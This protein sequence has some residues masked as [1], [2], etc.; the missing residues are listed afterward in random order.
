VS[1]IHSTAVIS[2]TVELSDNVEIGPYAVIEG[3]TV[4]GPGVRVGPHAVVHGHVLLAAGV[5]VGAHAMLGGE[6]QDLS[7]R[8]GPTDLAVGRDTV[9]REA[10]I[11]HRSTNPERPTRVGARCLLMGQSHVAHDCQ[12]D[13]Q[14]ILSHGASLAGHVTVGFGAVVGGKAGVHQH[15]RIGQLSMVGGM[16]AV[17]RDVLPFSLADGVPAR[18]RRLNTLGLERAGMN[19]EEYRSLCTVFQQLRVQREIDV[20]CAGDSVLALKDF[21]AVTSPRGISG[22]HH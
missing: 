18:H 6:P 20:G 1:G 5:Q 14:V 10:A 3:P 7:Y 4:V 21:L 17:V 13:D 11:L 2:A 12:L 15:V 8:G 9:I 22:F 19:A 16:A